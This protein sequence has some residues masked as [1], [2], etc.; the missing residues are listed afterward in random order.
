MRVELG[1][2][3]TQMFH[4]SLKDLH[5]PTTHQGA[6]ESSDTADKGKTPMCATEVSL[7]SSLTQAQVIHELQGSDTLSKTTKNNVRKS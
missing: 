6:V 5:G 4:H 1:R 7:S 2:M 3:I